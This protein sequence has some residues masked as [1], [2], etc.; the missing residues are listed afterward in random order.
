MISSL[1]VAIS[2][3]LS[4]EDK[5]RKESKSVHKN[6]SLNREQSRHV[7]SLSIILCRVLAV[8]LLLEIRN[9]CSRLCP[10]FYVLY[11]EDKHSGPRKKKQL[12][13]AVPKNNISQPGTRFKNFLLQVEKVVVVYLGLLSEYR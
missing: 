1:N 10:V 4:H 11:H 9:Y 7:E 13:Q 8:C 2:R 6:T 12:S 3:G 5:A